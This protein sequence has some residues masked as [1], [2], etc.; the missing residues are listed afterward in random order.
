MRPGQPGRAISQRGGGAADRIGMGNRRLLHPPDELNIICVS[1]RVNRRR[2]NLKMIFKLLGHRS[3]V[4]RFGILPQS[5]S[6]QRF[7]YLSADE[8]PIVFSWAP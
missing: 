4:T 2:L 5:E 1:V 3:R 8:P 6:F 7:L